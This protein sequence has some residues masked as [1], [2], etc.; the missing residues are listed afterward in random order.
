MRFCF[1]LILMSALCFVSSPVLGCDADLVAL[2]T[3]EKPNDVF[4]QSINLLASQTRVF[5]S[6]INK[7]DLAPGYLSNLMKSW[8]PFDNR[9][10]QTPPVWAAGDEM[11]TAKFKQLADDIGTID[12]EFRA[13]RLTDAHIRTLAFS[14]KLVKLFDRMPKSPEKAALITVTAAFQ[15]FS[16]AALSSDVKLLGEGVAGLS[17]GSAELRLYLASSTLPEIGV[18]LTHA[19]QVCSACAQEPGIMPRNIGMLVSIAEDSFGKMNARLRAH[20]QGK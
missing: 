3:G 7:P 17:S 18:F 4:S 8:I 6:N 20:S 2:F 13:G 9:F 16:E 10:S 19:D 12:R 15:T 14:R 11:W 1:A 5:G